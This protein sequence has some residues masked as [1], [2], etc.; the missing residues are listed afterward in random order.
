MG[1]LRN[2][3][4]LIG[5]V[6]Q[7][8]TIT[9]LESGRK[10]ARFSL[11]TNEFYKKDKGEKVQTTEWHTVVAWGKTADLIEN[12]VVKGKELALSGKLKSRSYED[13]EGVTRYVTEIEASEILLMG[14]KS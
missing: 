12:Y 1:T 11:A 10:V 5:N 9:N 3:V 6:G 2:H 7:E 8:P 14:S 4:Q 13:K